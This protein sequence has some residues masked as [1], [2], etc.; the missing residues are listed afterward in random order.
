MGKIRRN[1]LGDTQRFVRFFT[2]LLKLDFRT[3]QP[4]HLT[5]RYQ[6]WSR[7]LVALWMARTFLGPGRWCLY[8]SF[9][10]G[11]EKYYLFFQKLWEPI[12]FGF[13]EYCEFWVSNREKYD[14]RWLKENDIREQ[15]WGA[16]DVVEAAGY[17]ATT[18]FPKIRSEVLEKP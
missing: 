17:L 10:G 9:H 11:W 12:A 2:S 18:V 5:E 8:T 3:E 16:S 13:T 14:L 1:D 7:L 15:V 6:K 4:R